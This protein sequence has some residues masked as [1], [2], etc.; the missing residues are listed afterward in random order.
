MPS[1]VPLQ[2]G[3]Q[4]HGRPHRYAAG[5][6]V[7]CSDLLHGGGTDRRQ[8][9]SGHDDCIKVTFARLASVASDNSPGW[10]SKVFFPHGAGSAPSWQGPLLLAVGA[11]LV[12]T[13]CS[14]IYWRSKE[15]MRARIPHR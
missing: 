1:T 10:A 15:T 13:V 11:G 8:R 5:D 3:G 6:P 9:P 2:E 12:A 4:Q 7:L 14:E